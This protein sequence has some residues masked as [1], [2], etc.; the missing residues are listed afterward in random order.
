[1]NDFRFRSHAPIEIFGYHPDDPRVRVQRKS[2]KCPFTGMDCTKERYRTDKE[3]SGSCSVSHGDENVIICP[4]RFSANDNAIIMK[5]SRQRLK[6]KNITL[7]PE[8]TLPGA[9][10]R[11][12]WVAVVTANDGSIINLLPIETHANQTTSTGGLTDS[13]M[14]HETKGR[15]L[16]DSYKYGL[17]T[18]HQIK[19]FFTQCLMKSQLF[20]SWGRKCVWILDETVYN[21][22][23]ERFHLTF[24]AVNPADTIFFYAY[25]LDF[26]T[27][28]NKY[29]LVQRGAFSTNRRVLL[30]AYTS[31]IEELPTE[32]EFISTIMRKMHVQAR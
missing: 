18:Y 20:E 10:G 26:D 32:K 16:K 13:I 21:S 15:L 29:N 7:I 28:S 11:V 17:N 14:E 1:M 25:G 24:D 30:E 22:W 3:P 19:T 4:K 5:L 9:F 23:R 6:S 8:V 12:D 31:P 2:Q 27:T